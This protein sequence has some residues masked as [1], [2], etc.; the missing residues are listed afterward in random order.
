LRVDTPSIQALHDHRVQGDIDAAAR[1]EQRREERPRPDLRDL[2]GHV[3]RRGRDQLVAGAVAQIG[4][5]L[6][7]LVR[8]GADERRASAST[9]NCSIVA[10]SWRIRSPPS[11]LRIA[12]N[13]STRAD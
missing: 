12:S 8:F 11:A 10:N 3:A 6:A 4:A 7:A 1:C 5:G 9:N 13:S 2:A